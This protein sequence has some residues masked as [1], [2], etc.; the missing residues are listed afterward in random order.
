LKED[1]QNEYSNHDNILGECKMQL[2]DLSTD[3][4]QEKWIKLYYNGR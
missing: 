4:G 2:K 1:G 3:F